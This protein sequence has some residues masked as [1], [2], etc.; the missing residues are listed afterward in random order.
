MRLTITIAISAAACGPV[1]HGPAPQHGG[2]GGTPLVVSFDGGDVELTPGV[3]FAFAP[4]EPRATDWP[5]AATPWIA[6]DL[7][8]NGAIDNGTELFGDHTVLADGTYAPNGFVALAQLDANHDGRIDRDDPGFAA[9]LLWAD[10]DADGRSSP[11]ELAPL[12]R[13]IESISLATRV[14]PRCDS[15]GN[16]QRERAEIRWRDRTGAVRTGAVIDV[17]LLWR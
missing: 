13:T 17:Y 6:I 12:S 14:V 16:C 10:R 4:G 1:P 9:L 7:D 15:R 11:D 8:G 2:G 5:T 3:R